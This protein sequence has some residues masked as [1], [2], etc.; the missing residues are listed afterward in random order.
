[1][2]KKPSKAKAL[3]IYPP[4]AGDGGRGVKSIYFPLGIS[5]A[6][7]VIRE[8]YDVRIHDLNLDF[9][10]NNDLSDEYLRKVLMTEPYDVLLIGGVFPKYSFIKRLI[11]FSRNICDSKIII[12][13]SFIRPSIHVISDYLN[14]DYYVLGEA[15]TSI[16]PLLDCIFSLQP[17]HAVPNIAYQKDGKIV[18][19]LPPTKPLILDS[20]PFPAR[21]LLDFNIYKRYFAK[22]QPLVYQ[23]HI[24]ASRGCAFN[25]LF[26]NP[27]FGRNPNVRSPEN[28]LAEMDALNRDYGCLYFHM[29]DEMLL[30]GKSQL[31]EEFC[32]HLIIHRP[33]RYVWGGDCKPSV[34]EQENAR[35]HAAG[36]MHSVGI[37]SGIR[38]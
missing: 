12:G 7:A 23:S 35:A 17:V 16:L 13:G 36:R 33:G 14:A 34:V 25:C 21:D 15:E 32:N 31:I 9:N 38:K 2:L 10:L 24:V 30:G 1:M 19:T 3:L 5:Y 4:N 37:W 27:A 29:A 6:A 26:C 28:I 8:D 18:T 11:E 22:S 20:V